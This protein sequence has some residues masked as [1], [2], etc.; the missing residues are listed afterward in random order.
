MIMGL[1][2]IYLINKSYENFGKFNKIFWKILRKFMGNFS[3][4]YERFQE[5][6][7]KF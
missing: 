5:I 1:V 3:K 6:L 4:I 2:Y 7:R